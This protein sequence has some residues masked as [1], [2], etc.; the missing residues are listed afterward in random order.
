M[1]SK[2]S[3]SSNRARADRM[4]AEERDAFVAAVAE[5]LPNGVVDYVRLNIDARAG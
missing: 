1:R 4:A 2:S 5:R 3:V